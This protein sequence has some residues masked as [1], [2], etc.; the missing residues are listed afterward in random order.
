LKRSFG[1]AVLGCGLVVCGAGVVAQ[2]PPPRPAVA[3]ATLQR[4]LLLDATRVGSRIVA[5]G[6]RGTIVLSDDEGRTWRGAQ[7]PPA[8][9]LTAVAFSGEGLGLAVGHDAVILAT[10]DRGETWTQ[11]FS[12]PA[13]QRPLLDVLAL[14]AEH[15]IAVG[16]YGA[17]YE[18]ADGG[19]TWNAR[20]VIADDRHLNALVDA[21]GGHLVMLGEAGT[22]L[23]SPDRGATWSAVA[24]P[25]KG[26]FFGGVAANDGSLVAF[27]LRGR[28]FRS[29]DR[30]ATWKPV[31]NARV[32]A[33]MGADRLPDGALVVA[34]AAGNAL[35]SRDEGRSFVPITTGTTRAF[36]KPLLG[37]PNEVL[38]FGEAGI[39]SVAVPSA[40]AQAAR[41]TTTRS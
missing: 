7:A 39:R 9:L 13:E 27:G 17:Y 1:A 14:D 26:S 20:K 6:D 18:S 33:L 41:I 15:A 29:S 24:S 30:G 34:G 38:L 4:L 22:I 35:V 11:V 5:V 28:I 40:A 12:A 19:R 23:V 10:R 36:S 3:A 32:A 37:G 2:S 21:G 8:P 31:D 25:Y 16:A